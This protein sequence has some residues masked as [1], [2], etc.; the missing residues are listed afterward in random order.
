MPKMEVWVRI[1]V[2][3]WSDE[4]RTER[5]DAMEGPAEEKWPARDD[6][7]DGFLTMTWNF[8]LPATPCRH[9]RH[10]NPTELACTVACR[11]S[12]SAGP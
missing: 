11:C 2:G 9:F 8:L 4:G 7:D 6:D 12:G 1:S 5:S 3:E 10:R